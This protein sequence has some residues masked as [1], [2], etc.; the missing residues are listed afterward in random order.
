MDEQL[1]RG[2]GHVQAVLEELVDRGDRLLV[3]L[4]RIPALEDLADEHF[5]QG[6][7]KLVD[8]PPDAQLIIRDDRVIFKEYLTDVERHLRFLVGAADFLDL[9]H[10]CAVRDADPGEALFRQVCFHCLCGFRDVR[11][12][13]VLP[14]GAHDDDVVLVDRRDEIRRARA[15]EFLHRLQCVALLVRDRL[16]NHDDALRVQRNAELLRAPVDI[17]KQKVVEQEV[18]HER[19][20]VVPL[21]ERDEKAADLQRRKAAHKQRLLQSSLQDE[22]IFELMLVK[23]FEKAELPRRLRIRL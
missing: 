9:I 22:D 4:V 15:D 2:L 3:E 14:E 10:D 20:P 23:H 13:V 5:A 7:R 6:D 18:L 11:D 17:D 12:L 8:E 1:A 21:L 19:I 16:D